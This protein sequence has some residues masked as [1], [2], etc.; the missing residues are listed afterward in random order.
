[1]NALQ[2]GKASE[3]I[4][5]AAAYGINP[6][7]AAL[8]AAFMRGVNRTRMLKFEHPGLG[9]TATRVGER[10][11]LQNDIGTTDTHVLVVH[12]RGTSV[13]VTYT[14]VH[15]QRLLFFQ[16]LLKSQAVRWQDTLSRTDREMEEG[17]YHL[18]RLVH[19]GA[20]IPH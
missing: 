14:D 12:V 5:G 19:G 18:C 3:N 13:T 7:F 6:G 17:V 11:V 1:M 20:V 8:V 16:S 9:T 2:I 4:D 10:V 15:I